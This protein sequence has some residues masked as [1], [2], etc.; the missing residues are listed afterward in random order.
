MYVH[1][2][3]AVVA[4]MFRF[5]RQSLITNPW[6]VDAFPSRSVSDAVSAVPGHAGLHRAGIAVRGL[7]LHVMSGRVMS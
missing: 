7:L 4:V 1:H 3:V 5:R 6:W 2:D